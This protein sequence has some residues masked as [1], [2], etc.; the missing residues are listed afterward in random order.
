MI[1]YNITFNVEDDISGEWLEWIKNTFIPQ[2][3]K[4][5][6]LAGAR[7]SQLLVDEKQGT[8]YALQFTAENL[9]NLREFQARELGN[10]LRSMHEKFGDKVVF[11]PTEMKVI[12]SPE[13]NS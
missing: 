11:F 1:I 5:G 12:H 6:L 3:Q 9:E 7:L 8:S 10:Y 4:S 2:M 13:T